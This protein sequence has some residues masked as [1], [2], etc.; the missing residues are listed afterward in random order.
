M[1]LFTCVLILLSSRRGWRRSCTPMTPSSGTW[2]PLLFQNDPVYHQAERG[3]LCSHQGGHVLKLLQPRK[4]KVF[5][6]KKLSPEK[7]CLVKKLKG[8]MAC[9]VAS[10]AIFLA[11][12]ITQV[13]DSIPWVRSASGN[14]LHDF[15]LFVIDIHK[16]RSISPFLTPFDHFQLRPTLAE[17]CIP[18][19]RVRLIFFDA[20]P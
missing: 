20:S 5:P 11:A 17:K 7:I 9:G 1:T 8:V 2:S 4:K 15:T 13:M 12:E 10:V 19:L 16:N 18:D 3:G 6:E 14:V